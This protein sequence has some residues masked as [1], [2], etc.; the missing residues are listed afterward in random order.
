MRILFW[1][2]PEFAVPSLRALLESDSE[3]AGLICQPDR[4]RGRGRKLEAPPTKK[5]ATQYDIKVI[6]PEKP[7][8]GQLLQ[9]LTDLSYDLS[10]VVA[11]GKILKPD[12]LYLPKHG[13]I[14]VHASLLPKFRG[15]AP[16]NWTIIAG[17]METGIT[18]I[19]MDEGMDTG[20]ILLQRKIAVG[21][22][23]TAG[24]LSEK[25]S[26]LGAEILIETVSRLEQG[27]LEPSMQDHSQAIMAP[28]LRKEDARID[29][30]KSA[31]QIEREIRGFDPYPGSHT[32]YGS[33]PLRIFAAESR[34]QFESSSAEAGKI[35]GTG[36][37]G[38]TVQ[39]GS[40][41]LTITELQPAGRRRMPADEFLR[42]H[43]MAP[44]E[45]FH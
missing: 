27:K 14:N 9:Q 16:I 3:V 22:K 31:T 37:E 35:V 15:A 30:T 6:Q 34:N 32:I 41:I 20:D 23:A 43:S 45:R 33:E 39:T 44:G 5:L 21:P 19:Q 17:E 26:R 38:I 29:W 1:G 13:S 7:H 4:P 40:G 10:V 18:T 24:E 36:K 28:K 11:Y 25:L 2:T 42:G 8:G 12:V